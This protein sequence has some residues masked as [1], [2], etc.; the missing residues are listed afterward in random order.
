MT[1]RPITCNYTVQIL[2]LIVGDLMGGRYKTFGY[3]YKYNISSSLV[4]GLYTIIN[5]VSLCD[6]HIQSL[7]FSFLHFNFCF[8]AFLIDFNLKSYPSCLTYEN[9][10][11]TNMYLCL[12]IESN[13]SIQFK[14]LVT[15]SLYVYII[16]LIHYND[17]VWP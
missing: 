5:W 17:K 3:K 1:G 4:W 7:A 16:F 6:C 8:T 2:P 13:C 11:S 12:S 15:T 10:F 9:T 14:H